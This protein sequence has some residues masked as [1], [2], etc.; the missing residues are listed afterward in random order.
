VIPIWTTIRNL[1]AVEPPLARIALITFLL[2]HL[3]FLGYTVW[4]WIG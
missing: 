1:R 2:L 4:S 3:S